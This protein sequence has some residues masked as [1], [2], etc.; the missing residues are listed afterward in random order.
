MKR[1]RGG[2]GGEGGRGKGEEDRGYSLLEGDTGD[3]DVIASRDKG[4]S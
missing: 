1:G 4:E 2:G 3:G